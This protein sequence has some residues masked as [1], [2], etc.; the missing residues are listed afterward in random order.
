[1][2]LDPDVVLD[3]CQLLHR[4]RQLVRECGHER[5]TVY[6]AAERL[7]ELHPDVYGLGWIGQSDCRRLTHI[8]FRILE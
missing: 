7:G 6:R 2:R 8:I 3:Q 1:Q 4:L 5:L